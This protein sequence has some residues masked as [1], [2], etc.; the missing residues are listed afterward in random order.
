M[1]KKEIAVQ[2]ATPYNWSLLLQFSGFFLLLGLLF[3]ESTMP[4]LTRW[5]KWDEDLSHAIPTLLALLFLISRV[6][7]LPYKADSNKI[8]TLFIVVVAVLS[9][10]W[11]LFVLANIT[12]L[13]NLVLFAC[14]PLFLAACYSTRTTIFLIPILGLLVFVLPIFS[15]LNNILV[16]LS[17]LAV[18]FLVKLCGI[19]A[20]I[21]GQ[22]IFIP[23]GH[24]FIAD[25]CSGLRYLT[26]SLL[27]GY[28]LSI[29]N[30]Y[31]FA[32]TLAALAVATLLGLLTNWLR[33]F[34]L[35]IIGDV[36]QMKSSL[37]QDHELF[38]WVLF[39]CVMLPAIFFS[40]LEPKKPVEKTAE[41]KLKL[42]LPLIALI[43]GP[44]ILKLIPNFDASA[45]KLSLKSANLTVQS[46][47]TSTLLPAK[48]PATPYMEYANHKSANTDLHVQLA[49]YRPESS[50]DK[51][52]PY[53]GALYGNEEW[54]RV[55][56]S[57]STSLSE[58]GY[59]SIILKRTGSQT[60][61]ILVYRF[62]I[63][64]RNTSHYESAKMLQIPAIFS[65]KRYFNV[66]SIHST[67]SEPTCGSELASATQIALDWSQSTQHLR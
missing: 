59:K 54:Q 57:T 22:S 35:V 64:A 8:R 9:A 38:G 15:Q 13:A 53:L 5:L 23:Y 21:D 26:I 32:K 48:L 45:S 58:Q 10:I 1:D 49:Q 2:S 60:Y 40:P 37:M 24:I 46:A 51:I 63:G 52:I 17:S 41:P 3:A 4:L 39:S 28:L 62:E 55:S 61:A 65:G 31:S 14:I 12:L 67:C 25:G 36:T 16:Q 56:D 7:H 19:T 44:L 11:L 33:I 47:A 42:I 29:L 6:E 27:L 43:I 30:H 20:L 34:L 50:K 66:F 18:G